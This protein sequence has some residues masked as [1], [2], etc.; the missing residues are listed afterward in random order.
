MDVDFVEVRMVTRKHLDLSEANRRIGVEG[1]P[2]MTALH[3]CDEHTVGGGFLQDPARSVPTQQSSRRQFDVVEDGEVSR[4][5]Q[6]DC[7]SLGHQVF[8]C[9]G[10]AIRYQIDLRGIRGHIQ[11]APNLH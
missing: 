11:Q 9:R 7:I 8:R 4:L 3:R 5:R 1:N 10:D 2:Q 6:H